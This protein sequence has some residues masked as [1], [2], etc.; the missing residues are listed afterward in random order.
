MLLDEEYPTYL[1]A[2][3][4]KVSDL[5]YGE[6]PHQTAAYYVS[7]FENGAMKDFEQLGGK[8][9][10]FNNLRDMD[11]CWK[12]VTEF[13]EEMACCA[14]KHSTPCGV[15]IGTSA[16]KLIRKLSNVIRFPSL[17]ELLL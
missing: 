2:S 12:V 16:W 5:R 17:A 13:K 4:K 11:L 14:V 1:N 3:Y 7:T 8:E 9:L 10:S 15:A 6:N